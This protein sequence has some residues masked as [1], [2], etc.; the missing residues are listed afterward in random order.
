ML[1]F[2]LPTCGATS[3]VAS[4]FTVARM[5]IAPSLPPL[6]A[7]RLFEKHRN[8][9]FIWI[10]VVSQFEDQRRAL[11]WDLATMRAVKYTPQGEA[12]G[13]VLELMLGPRSHEQEVA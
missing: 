3:A 1:K 6:A 5:R 8:C 13:S 9:N 11:C 7:Q 2:S 4:Q 12:L 10:A